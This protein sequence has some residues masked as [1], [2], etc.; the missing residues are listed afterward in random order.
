[1]GNAFFLAPVSE[2]VDSLSGHSRD[3]QAHGHDYH[4]GENLEPHGWTLTWALKVHFFDEKLKFF[5]IHV[6]WLFAFLLV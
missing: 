1:M 3:E 5:F 4:P 2:P 6:Y